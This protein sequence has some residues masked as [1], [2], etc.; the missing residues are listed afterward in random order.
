MNNKQFQIFLMPTLPL[1]LPAHRGK[2]FMRML[3][4]TILIFQPQNIAFQIGILSKLIKLQ[5]PEEYSLVLST[6][7][8]TI[9]DNLN[10]TH[11]GSDIEEIKM[12][13]NLSCTPSSRPRTGVI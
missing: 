8:F 2:L 6:D 11:K 3:F 9:K 10:I 5:K 4:R 12:A 1:I 13:K 7:G